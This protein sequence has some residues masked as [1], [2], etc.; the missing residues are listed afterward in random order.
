MSLLLFAIYRI[1]SNVQQNHFPIIVLYH[2][3][4]NIVTTYEQHLNIITSHG[5]DCKLWTKHPIHVA[6]KPSWC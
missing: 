5:T 4:N 6:S 1:E 3:Y 2:M